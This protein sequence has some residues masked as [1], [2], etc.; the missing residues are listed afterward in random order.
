MLALLFVS[1]DTVPPPAFYSCSP[2]ERVV[3][4]GYNGAPSA[5]SSSE[6][7]MLQVGLRAGAY[8]C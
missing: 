5:L 1:L 8:L 6:Q 3:L 4:A 7:F 2:D